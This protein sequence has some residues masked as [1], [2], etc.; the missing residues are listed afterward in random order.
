MITIIMVSIT[1]IF[2]PV[3][4]MLWSHEQRLYFVTTLGQRYDKD[5]ILRPW[6]TNA[7]VTAF[8]ER[9]EC[10]VKQYSGYEMFGYNVGRD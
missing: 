6:W 1:V 4:I 10:F 3:P 5:G 9:Q 8:Q 7:S 2:S